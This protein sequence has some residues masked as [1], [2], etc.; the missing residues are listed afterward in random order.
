MR[1]SIHLRAVP[2]DLVYCAPPCLCGRHALLVACGNRA[3]LDTCVRR[4]LLITFGLRALRIVHSA[5][6]H[7][8]YARSL[9]FWKVPSLFLLCIHPFLPLLPLYSLPAPILFAA[10]ARPLSRSF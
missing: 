5:L 4:V 3:L 9:T 8:P 10:S 7:Y 1:D 6:S 2:A